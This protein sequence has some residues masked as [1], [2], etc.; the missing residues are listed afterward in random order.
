MWQCSLVDRTSDLTICYK[1]PSLCQRCVK[2]DN[3]PLFCGDL[4]SAFS[5][6]AVGFWWSGRASPEL[7]IWDGGGE[8]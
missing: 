1:I 5:G 7:K 3:S 6:Y 4:S 8:N 2:L